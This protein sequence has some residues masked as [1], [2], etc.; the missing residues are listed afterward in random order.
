MNCVAGVRFLGTGVDAVSNSFVAPVLNLSFFSQKRT[1]WSES[2]QTFVSVPDGV[3]VSRDFE[4]TLEK[5]VFRSEEQ[6]ARHLSRQLVL[7]EYIPGLFSASSEMLVARQM[8]QEGRSAFVLVEEFIAL[9]RLTVQFAPG[10]F[11][12][13]DVFDSALL[14]LPKSYDQQA[15]FQFISV[16]GTHVT[17]DVTLGG[18]S[19]SEGFSSAGYVQN[20]TDFVAH[21]NLALAYSGLKG[22]F[23]TSYSR[24]STSSSFSETSEV[25]LR[26][27]GGNPTI[28]NWT[29]WLDSVPISPMPVKFAMIP[30]AAFV[31]DNVLKS[32]LARAVNDYISRSKFTNITAP[33]SS[34]RHDIR[35]CDCKT[36][37][38][39]SKTLPFPEG[40]AVK[41]VTLSNDFLVSPVT[42]CRPCLEFITDSLFGTP[43]T[44]GNK[45]PGIQGAPKHLRSF[46]NVSLPLPGIDLVGVG[47]DA[48]QG[49]FR[50][51][52]ILSQ[53]N[54]SSTF[55]N[56][57]TKQRYFF[58]QDISLGFASSGSETTS[59]LFKSANELTSFLSQ[60]VGIGGSFD[61]FGASVS[62]R[63]SNAVFEDGQCFMHY[64]SEKTTLYTLLSESQRLDDNFAA[65]VS[66]ILPSEFD[67]GSYALFVQLFGTHYVRSADVGGRMSM[68]IA[69]DTEYYA[70]DSAKSDRLST[71]LFSL[72]QAG[73]NTSVSSDL[74]EFLQRTF[75]ETEYFG[76]DFRTMAAE[77]SHKR[78]QQSLW[79]LPVVVQPRLEPIYSTL[80]EPQR[81]NM[82][83]FIEMYAGNFTTAPQ[84]VS[85]P[86]V[87]VVPFTYGFFEPSN[88][89]LVCPYYDA[90][91]I[92][93]GYMT[94]VTSDS[95]CVD[96]TVAPPCA[97]FV[98][99][100]NPGFMIDASRDDVVAGPGL[101]VWLLSSSFNTATSSDCDALDSNNR[102]LSEWASGPLWYKRAFI[103]KVN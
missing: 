72:F 48:V 3:V 37:N 91:A 32:N 92:N 5:N 71:Q 82:Q 13:T 55:V 65:A 33:P 58:P 17:M 98:V 60:S 27:Y 103:R 10:L 41:S 69:V 21:G 86:S 47:F 12:L 83:K 63:Q 29:D 11:R 1:W 23:G 7:S 75:A 61:G 26:R 76:G 54:M 4:A 67:I 9:H 51:S 101:N 70:K 43:V 30:L 85:A 102:P 100:D 2:Q 34:P 78:W 94:G 79:K 97:T 62:A 64:V 59:L 28:Q 77:G 66:I 31:V 74:Q 36:D 89:S 20:N 8:L 25:Q 68:N 52:R 14:G 15:Y 96:L 35:Q 45:F 90:V 22:K 50:P 88:T 80:P 38:F 6:F 44:K 99:Q 57:F 87:S 16:F 42:V 18:K 73:F 56:P 49:S 53:S 46:S 81:S 93:L 24:A 95:Y 84:R 19:S 40:F 39:D